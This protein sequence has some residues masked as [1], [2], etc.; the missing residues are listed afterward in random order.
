MILRIIVTTH[1][2]GTKT[3]KRKVEEN[4]PEPKK[5]KGV[6][7]K[8]VVRQEM[9]YEAKHQIKNTERNNLDNNLDTEI[10]KVLLHDIEHKPFL[11]KHDSRV[12]LSTTADGDASNLSRPKNATD[13]GELT[14]NF[15]S[16]SFVY[17]KNFT[18]SDRKRFAAYCAKEYLKSEDSTLELHKK[19]LSDNIVSNFNEITS[20][21]YTSLK[22]HTLLACALHYNYLI[23]GKRNFEELY[24]NCI[25][26]DKIN[27]REYY[28]IIFAFD[29]VYLAINTDNDGGH[30]GYIP[31]TNFGETIGRM[32]KLDKIMTIRN[33][34]SF[35][36]D[37][38]RRIRSW[39]VGL[40]YL[41]DALNKIKS[42]GM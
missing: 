14:A 30:I 29:D 22:Y 9:K 10:R 6:P 16:K 2:D 13:D 15:L 27:E 12:K 20:M 11:L 3:Y 4:H 39:S 38:L 19:L 36:I 33:E 32:P 24:L 17:E 37:N 26:K 41:E 31:T 18:E 7:D 25:D 5:I 8:V 40:Q 28:T 34:T 1:P 42:E 21:P 35:I 23:K